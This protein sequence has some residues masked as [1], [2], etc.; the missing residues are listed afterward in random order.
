MNQSAAEFNTAH[1]FRLTDD[2][3]MF[4]HTRYNVPDLSKGYTTDDNARALIMVVM[5]YEI[6]V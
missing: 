5:L 6:T 4:Q 2:T 3:G 1:I